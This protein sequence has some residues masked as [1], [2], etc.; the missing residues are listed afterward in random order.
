MKLF[1]VNINDSEFQ[2][3]AEQFKITPRALAPIVGAWMSAQETSE[4]PSQEVIKV[5]LKEKGDS[6][7]VFIT[8]QQFDL[9]EADYK[10]NHG[11]TFP[12]REGIAAANK[13]ILLQG[14][15]NVRL[16]EESDTQVR[17]NISKPIGKYKKFSPVIF[18]D[19]YEEA[20]NEFALTGGAYTANSDLK[21]T[22]LLNTLGNLFKP[23]TISVFQDEEDGSYEVIVQEP[24]L[25]DYKIQF[26]T[27]EQDLKTIPEEGRDWEQRLQSQRRRVTLQ[28]SLMEE[29]DFNRDGT[30][31]KSVLEEIRQEKQAIIEK[32]KANGT[33]LKAPNG[34][35][36]NLTAEQ[37]VLVRT[38]RFKKWFGDWERLANNR[39]ELESI[40]NLE[41]LDKRKFIKNLKSQ[42]QNSFAFSKVINREA[43]SIIEKLFDLEAFE[44][45][46]GDISYTK[47]VSFI[48][49]AI[50]LQKQL[51]DEEA[52][53][54]FVHEVIHNFT[55]HAYQTNPDFRK[56]MD[57]YHKIAREHNSKFSANIYEFM[58]QTLDKGHANALLAIPSPN[59]QKSNLLKDIIETFIRFLRKAF[60]NSK[61]NGKRTLFH[62]I[63]ESIY[64]NQVSNEEF[65]NSVS[66]I[67]DENREPLP[68]YHQTNNDF[69]TFDTTPKASRF[70][71]A[72]PRG[73]FTKPTTEKIS[74]RGDKQM[75][76]FARGK[77]PIVFKNRTELVQHLKDNIPE[78]AEKIDT[79][80]KL[81]NSS[82][83]EDILTRESLA[84]EVKPIV[85]D[86]FRNLG[87]DYVELKDDYSRL[88]DSHIYDARIFLDSNQ[89]KSTVDNEGTYSTTNDDIRYAII[90]ETL[91]E[92]DTGVLDYSQE[93]MLE[94]NDGAI[95]RSEAE[96]M[97]YQSV[98]DS[99]KQLKTI[100]H[101]IQGFGTT[102]K[103]AQKLSNLNIS[104][105][106]KN[107]LLAALKEDSSLSKL[108]PI[109]LFQYIV[110]SRESDFAADYMKYIQEPVNAALEKFLAEWLERYHI[111][112]KTIDMSRFGDNI[113]GAF[114]I[115][116][117][118]IYV[119]KTRNKATLPEEF[120]HAFV[121]LMGSVY[122]KNVEK[123]PENKDFSFLMDTVSNT[124]IFKKVY[125]EYKNIYKKEDGTEDMYMIKKEAIGQAL[126]TALISNFENIHT[127]QENSFWEKIKDL[128]N[129]IL[130][131]FSDAEYLSF[132]TLINKM[133]EE[134]LAKNYSRLNKVD[135]SNYSLLGY[136]ETLA[137][138]T[139]QDGGK[140]ISFMQFFTALGNIITGSLSYRL[141]GTVYRGKLD[142][143][144]DID[145][146]V[147]QSVSKLQMT[148]ATKS[149]FSA[150][151]NSA[152]ALDYIKQL[153][154]FKTVLEKYP[155]LL[156]ISAYSDKK[157]G[158][159]VNSVYSEN[160]ELSRRFASYEGSYVSRLEKFTEEERKQIYLFDFFLVAKE[161]V[162]N[163]IMDNENNIRLAG[164]QQ[165]FREKQFVLGRA[166]DIYDYQQWNLFEQYKTQA[167][168][169]ENLMFQAVGNET[170]QIS[171][172]ENRNHRL[173]SL[174]ADRD[175]RLA[176]LDI[177]TMDELFDFFKGSEYEGIIELLKS[178]DAKKL[179]LDEV[180]VKL[181]DPFAFARWYSDSRMRDFEGKSA[182]Y[183]AA[184]NT[185]HINIRANFRNGN[186]ESIILHEIMHAITVNR[187]LN[188]PQ[189]RQYFEDVLD[190]YQAQA[191]NP[192]YRRGEQTPNYLEEF[193]ADIWSDP[194]VINNLKNIKTKIDKGM[195]LWDKIKGFFNKFFNS[196]VKDASPDSLFVKASIGLDRLMDK[197]IFIAKKSKGIFHEN[198]TSAKDIEG[199]Y[200]KLGDKTKSEHV[201]IA[202]WSKLKDLTAPFTNKGN[203]VTTR[204]KG[205]T[206][207]NFGNTFT[208]D[209]KISDRNE[210][211][212][213]VE[214]TKEA[215]K[216]YIKSI[217]ISN[218]P[219][220]TWIREQIQ[221]G[222]LKGKRIIYYTE[223][224]QPSHATALDWLINSAES[225]FNNKNNNSP[226]ASN[227][228]AVLKSEKKEQKGVQIS[229][230]KNKVER[231]YTVTGS[232]IYNSKGDEVF[233][234]DV[235]SVK[236]DRNKIFANLAVKEGRA[237]VVTYGED[238]FVV[239]DKNQILSVESGQIMQWG[240]KDPD[241]ICVL[242]LAKDAFAAKDKKAA[243]KNL[244]EIVPLESESEEREFVPSKSNQKKLG[245][246]IFNW[247]VNILE[248]ISGRQGDRIAQL[249]LK[250]CFG[251]AEDLDLSLLE[252]VEIYRL[253]GNGD[254]S[255]GIA[256]LLRVVKDRMKKGYEKIGDNKY[257][258]YQI[259]HFE[260]LVN[261]ANNYFAMYLGISVRSNTKLE[262]NSE[263]N[264]DPE[265][266]PFDEDQ[267]SGKD[268]AEMSFSYKDPKNTVPA[269][270][271]RVLASVNRID[272]QGKPILDPELELE[273]S[274]NPK[275]VYNTLVFKLNG[276]A[277]ENFMDSLKKLQKKHPWVK[278]IYEQ[279]LSN[280]LFEAQLFI[281]IS[282][283]IRLYQSSYTQPSWEGK[284]RLDT[285]NN[286][287]LNE[288]IPIAD[289]RDSIVSR[290]IGRRPI[291]GD[292]FARQSATDGNSMVTV[293]ASEAELKEYKKALMA[294]RDK[295]KAGE[296]LTLNDERIL[297]DIADKFGVELDLDMFDM[298][299]ADYEQILYTISQKQD[300]GR[301]IS[302]EEKA[303][304]LKKSLANTFVGHLIAL[305][306]LSSE[307]I[308][309]TVSLVETNSGN[310]GLASRIYMMS[311]FL[312]QLGDEVVVASIYANRKQRQTF[313]ERNLIGSTIEALQGKQ[314]EEAFNKFVEE[315]Y[316]KSDWFFPYG[317]GKASAIQWLNDLKKDST[318]R[319]KLKLIEQVEFLGKEFKDL[320]GIGLYQ[321][322]LSNY[323]LDSSKNTRASR[324]LSGLARFAV[325]LYADKDTFDL[326]QFKTYSTE[327]IEEHLVDIAI[328]EALRIITL[329]QRRDWNKKNP[330]LHLISIPGFD[331]ETVDGVEIRNGAEFKYLPFL[332]S[333]Q[334]VLGA[335]EMF[336][337]DRSNIANFKTELQKAISEGME[338]LFIEEYAKMEESG[339]FEKDEKGT[340]IYLKDIWAFQTKSKKGKVAQELNIQPA[341]RR[342]FFNHYFAQINIL[343]LTVSDIAFFNSPQT[344]LKRF[345]MAHSPGTSLYTQAK[346]NGKLFSEDS[347]EK[348]IILTDIQNKLPE[349]VKQ[350]ILRIWDKRIEKVKG[351]AAEPAYKKVRER[352]EKELDQVLS[353]DGQG[354]RTL[355]GY[356]KLLGM[357]GKWS[358]EFE[359]RYEKIKSGNWTMEDMAA[360]WQPIKGFMATKIF[361]KANGGRDFSTDLNNFS[362]P[363][364]NKNSEYFLFFTAALL[365]S[366]IKK[367]KKRNLISG[368]KIAA[369]MEYADKH[370]IDLVQFTSAVKVG[371][372]GAIDISDLSL[373][374]DN[375]SG[376]Y[377]AIQKRLNDFIGM[378][379][380]VR[381]EFLQQINYKDYRIQQEIPQSLED[382]YKL[383]GTQFRKLM[384]GGLPDRITPRG[385]E[386]SLTKEEFLSRY[387][388]NIAKL[389]DL[390]VKNL[391]KR[392]NLK[393]SLKDGNL[394]FDSNQDMKPFIAAL[395]ELLR[396]EL[397]DNGRSSEDLI[398]ALD[399]NEQGDFVLPIAEPIHANR[400]CASLLALIRKTVIKQ[401]IKGGAAV[402]VAD[403][404]FNE[405]LN[406]VFDDEGNFKY[407]ECRIAPLDSDIMEAI[408]TT[409][410]KNGTFYDINKKDSRGNYIVP[411]DLRELVAYRIPTED[412]YSMFPLRI[413]GFLPRES[414]GAIQLP[415]LAALMSGFDYDIDKLYLFYAENRKITTPTSEYEAAERMEEELMSRYVA[416]GLNSK[417]YYESEI[418]KIKKIEDDTERSDARKEL[419]S[420]Y[421]TEVRFEKIVA[422]N[423]TTTRELNNELLDL[424]WG[425]LVNPDSAHRMFNVGGFQNLKAIDAELQQFLGNNNR[426][427]NVFRP[428]SQVFFHDNLSE[429][430]SLLGIYANH[431]TSH[432]SMSNRS[433][434]Y[435]GKNYKFNGRTIGEEYLDKE[436]DRDG[437][438]RVDIAKIIASFLAAAPD[439][440]K[441]PVLGYI[442]QNTDVASF[443]MFL[444]RMGVDER[445]ASFMINTPLINKVI[446]Q[447]RKTSLKSYTTLET[448]VN[449]ELAKQ[450]L[451]KHAI[452]GRT[453]A[454]ESKLEQ[455]E[456]DATGNG[457][458]FDV[459]YL[460]T[461]F[462]QTKEGMDA[463]L[464]CLAV[465]SD[466]LSYAEDLENLT[467][468]TKTD[469]SA[470]SFA[471]T[472]GAA[473][474]QIRKMNA[475]KEQSSFEYEANED[476]TTSDLTKVISDS[477]MLN[478][479]YQGNLKL[480]TA[481]L[482][483]LFPAVQ[484]D[485]FLRNDFMQALDM[486]ESSIAGSLTAKDIDDIISD[487]TMFK[488]TQEVFDTSLKNRELMYR[489]FVE[490]V[491]YPFKE[492]IN[493]EEFKKEY[494]VS[495]K[496]IQ[497]NAFIKTL[498]AVKANKKIPFSHIKSYTNGLEGPEID[499]IKAGWVDLLN[500][501]DETV[502]I[503]AKQM[504]LYNALLSGFKYSP[505]STMHLTPHEVLNAYVEKDAGGKGVPLSDALRKFKNLDDGKLANASDVSIFNNLGDSD[506]ATFV[507]QWFRNNST[508]RKF[509]PAI[510][511]NQKDFA[512]VN[513]K[514][515]LVFQNSV[516]GLVVDHY[517]HWFP[518]YITV[519]NG[520]ETKL[521][522]YDKAQ[523]IYQA[524]TPLGIMHFLKEY[525]YHNIG[526][527]MK[528]VILKNQSNLVEVEGVS[529]F[530]DIQI[531]PEIRD[532]FWKVIDEELTKNNATFTRETSLSARR[533]ALEEIIKTLITRDA[534]ENEI[535]EA[536]SKYQALLAAKDTLAELSEERDNIC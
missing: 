421:K 130:S 241:R 418:E 520:Q 121:E 285:I 156:L 62:D 355:G 107:T 474:Y 185:I 413:V 398:E 213:L 375:S 282:K 357:S 518:P 434:K 401:H 176:L 211:L 108:T 423:P 449:E 198:K 147:P 45:Y 507:D 508:S 289:T 182:Y 91:K 252:D 142:S 18:T 326:I 483:N 88:H 154:Y 407:Y 96:S 376:Y 167:I 427:I 74:L 124:E 389:I 109:Q 312:A 196:I 292:I 270:V 87:I 115:L 301:G 487:Y 274:V 95:L 175:D 488:L 309:S 335:F 189:A 30:V 58:A 358:R 323:F 7:K 311:A 393:Y 244:D 320:K 105:Y 28:K 374:K 191:F 20:A 493:S 338:Q 496:E 377:E 248:D 218:D 72:L 525:N 68:L 99:L 367:D 336:K 10:A 286:D 468:R 61:N 29:S 329:E 246:I 304:S 190:E 346:W 242:A 437:T 230:T 366:A 354:F 417:Q 462:N 174:K 451:S 288:K 90:E 482:G 31:K 360:A 98:M 155:K 24:K 144:H 404:M 459:E 521:Y 186:A 419:L 114:D 16:I 430:A 23:S 489:D 238:R 201:S 53:A 146:V 295:L 345:S 333:N 415:A 33:Y 363:T 163:I 8:K 13:S 379:S 102:K 334:D 125:E 473:I 411:E 119:A 25:E 9:A 257:A 340:F 197:D 22:K 372:V 321:A 80:Q 221:S 263:I 453:S 173:F 207:E 297:D 5:L 14:R 469:S 361:R 129:K 476:S 160:E 205:E 484:T 158:V 441:D 19:V 392:L 431:L 394:V 37:W 470:N 39:I 133:S 284:T 442:G 410:D 356:R 283:N 341:I 220:Y 76:L 79:I 86:Y 78:I 67:V 281:T 276:V 172:E 458:N 478:G 137:N 111:D 391:A 506:I 15:S 214:S 134:I 183:N 534:A 302:P 35:K 204:L 253:I 294:L 266:T 127:K 322:L 365:D 271:K 477:P 157:G 400:T 467:L 472:I 258:K 381:N 445:T 513:G 48:A 382:I 148:D 519:K 1:C 446:N 215:V 212:E 40:P 234:A 460:K 490:E 386:S 112:I 73:I 57:R 511:Y 261:L 42:L 287:I 202:P 332:N 510:V 192:K 128:F 310:S 464:N 116:N 264:L 256:N 153:D 275:T 100:N 481:I 208:S 351:T 303:E 232:H 342:F 501:K 60:D 378:E 249:I 515:N 497:R 359:K 94:D 456:I 184:T 500:H 195:S 387:E 131:I 188:D 44:L 529:Y 63:T 194:D 308:G 117:K 143:L 343:E 429:A 499:N 59:N 435:T 307:A 50:V 384:E 479:F 352:L 328:Q 383:F 235:P 369:V 245:K 203:I 164:Y 209:K 250:K 466:L 178:K 169:L 97:Y 224:N 388:T 136:A 373:T 403:T 300:V 106:I 306:N 416:A 269:Q 81:Q 251:I 84:S 34:K 135:A 260:E 504:V 240:E 277:P 32:A 180:A 138:Q 486:I 101:S 475:L 291:A 452:R 522:R 344:F 262:N 89:V 103:F 412:K 228:S 51:S 439:N 150:R 69:N 123:F 222:K 327:E 330:D 450:G 273:V 162:D 152:A 485:E 293:R 65:S 298:F 170:G 524:T 140:A 77:K 177:S 199:Y 279:A 444:I 12:R 179:G 3:L 461:A 181:V 390:S 110:D 331:I 299:D 495:Y 350:N 433:I 159:I 254:V 370:D 325:P 280:E 141:Q 463:A 255:T 171:K 290:I 399:V 247:Y 161:K 70:D 436:V 278:S 364:V 223:L 82:K 236:A 535:K 225:P 71:F 397:S 406:I 11:K 27:S 432:A 93:D 498:R 217:L 530:F 353:S 447:Y 268:V 492:R 324:E 219:H 243:S 424:I 92:F 200:N 527:S 237:V 267:L 56:E 532:A 319:D 533:V 149:L 314:G 448:I 528:S 347:I 259:D 509:V 113:A 371:G 49:G 420:L 425:A 502:S 52:A 132:N 408:K 494:P 438:Q 305:V 337:K 516:S 187:V 227:S 104:P 165:S 26:T 122:R 316:E 313:V 402:L 339:L 368:S 536:D 265:E 118:I 206:K 512:Y 491:F 517:L 362:V 315:N 443:T 349:E 526:N 55:T 317:K 210:G 2:N 422:N 126:A 272:S 41:E 454:F 47:G 409:D 54:V 233:K 231:T 166:K 17:L 523:G 405:D 503:F 36:S 21:L 193:I 46:R 75:S 385:W 471:P 514:A 296:Y 395:S 43:L 66:K 64:K 239:N 465:F 426:E 414:G 396:N 457:I 6:S 168:D 455:I 139:K 380:P 216:S 151:G 348:S 480:Y 83:K 4:F 120:A 38:K 229:Y 318:L 440:A 85:N 428:S 226:E 145:M 505:N 531:V